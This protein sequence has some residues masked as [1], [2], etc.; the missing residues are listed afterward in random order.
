[1]IK[2][3]GV[4]LITALVGYCIYAVAETRIDVRPAVTPIGTS[5]SDGE[6]FAWFYDPGDR[7]VYVCR[8]SKAAAAA[9]ECKGK[10]TLP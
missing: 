6:S 10:A 7:A 3:A 4:A 8:T 5:S 2:V 9:V 1:M